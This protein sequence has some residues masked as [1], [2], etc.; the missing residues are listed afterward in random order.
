MA[1]MTLAAEPLV[2]GTD[3]LFLAC[4][5]W[6][7]RGL[8]KR[9]VNGACRMCLALLAIARVTDWRPAPADLQTPVGIWRWG[10]R[11]AFSF[12]FLLVLHHLAELIA[13]ARE[14]RRR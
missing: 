13:A 3:G 5:A 8:G 4:C 12:M 9:G 6:V 2:A 7:W 1:T 10:L 14:A 11:A